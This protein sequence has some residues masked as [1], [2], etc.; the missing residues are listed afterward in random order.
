MKLTVFV[1][2]SKLNVLAMILYA[3][4]FLV[5]ELNSIYSMHILLLIQ[6]IKI[7]ASA[8]CLSPNLGNILCALRYTV[9][10]Y[11]CFANLPNS[12]CFVASNNL[13]QSTDPHLHA[14]CKG[15]RPSLSVI[16][17]CG[18]YFS[19]TSKTSSLLY[20]Q[21]SWRGLNPLLPLQ[22]MRAPS[23]NNCVTLSTSPFKVAPQSFQP[24]L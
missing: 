5:L 14:L 23:A 9:N 15:V 1:P 4:N 22:F 24:W 8:N 21:A 11:S 2:D 17:M 7:A 19:N 18:P 6:R 3:I 12:H 20:I 16:L 10:A 13:I